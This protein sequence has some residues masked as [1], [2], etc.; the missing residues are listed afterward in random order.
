[1]VANRNVMKK[2]N[3]KSKLFLIYLNE[4]KKMG[5]D[6]DMNFSLFGQQTSL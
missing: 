6:V 1:M 4:S 3:I 2:K 5:K